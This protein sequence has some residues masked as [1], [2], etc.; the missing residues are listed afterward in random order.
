MT[1]AVS[2]SLV[3]WYFSTSHI[4]LKLLLVHHLFLKIDLTG[5]LSDIGQSL[6]INLL[7]LHIWLIDHNFHLMTILR[8]CFSCSRIWA[9]AVLNCFI[10]VKTTFLP[11]F[12][13]ASYQLLGLWTFTF[14][15]FRRIVLTE[16]AVDA[17]LLSRNIIGKSILSIIIR[18]LTTISRLP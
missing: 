10:H 13:S 18:V 5:P 15:F 14:C 12:W 16:H 2:H 9:H 6:R 1:K 11:V 3:K 8:I 17:L 7:L 4:L